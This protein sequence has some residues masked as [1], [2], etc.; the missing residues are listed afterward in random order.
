MWQVDWDKVA[1]EQFK[2]MPKDFQQDWAE[3][4]AKVYDHE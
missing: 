4:R 3:L 1:K 2:H